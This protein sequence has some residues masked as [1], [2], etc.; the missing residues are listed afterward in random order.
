MNDTTNNFIR[1][2]TYAGSNTKTLFALM[3]DYLLFRDPDIDIGLG[4]HY[5]VDVVGS[6]TDGAHLL[7]IVCEN[8]DIPLLDLRTQPIAPIRDIVKKILETAPPR[9][10]ILIDT[11]D[12]ELMQKVRKRIATTECDLRYRR[13]IFCL[14]NEVTTQPRCLSVPGTVDDRLVLLLYHIPRSIQDQASSSECFRPLAQAMRDYSLFEQRVWK[15]VQLDGSLDA[16]L[17]TALYQVVR[18]VQVD[19]DLDL[20]FPSFE[21][22]W[23]RSLSTHLQQT[24]NP[25]PDALC[26]GIHRVVPVG[27]SSQEAL[28]AVQGAIPKNLQNPYTITINTA[29]VDNHCGSIAITQP[30]TYTVVYV[31]CTVNPD[32]LAEVCRELRVGHKAVVHEVHTMRQ[33]Q[34]ASREKLSELKQDIARLTKLVVRATQTNRVHEH[35]DQEQQ[36][37]CSKKRCRRPVTE[38]FRSGKHKRQ[39]SVCLSSLLLAKK[40]F[41]GV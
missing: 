17:S 20:D 29:A 21:T 35:E 41:L 24:L 4:A 15:L 26:P 11:R 25:P 38:R 32:I 18:R 9:C 2:V 33:D 10:A 39:C 12:N 19:A 3:T 1:A 37:Q 40:P 8:Q 7:E 16:F 28:Q 22:P 31:H 6:G 14:S 23:R 36:K 34:H 5:L 30:L 27:V 13:V